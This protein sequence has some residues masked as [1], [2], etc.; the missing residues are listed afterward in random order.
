[1]NPQQKSQNPN[2]H[3]LA[4]ALLELIDQPILLELEHRNR[5]SSLALTGTLLRAFDDPLPTIA[6]TLTI[7][8]GAHS[9]SLRL[10]TIQQATIHHAPLPP[11]RVRSVHLLLHDGYS[12]HIKPDPAITTAHP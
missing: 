4:L 9:I 2:I 7:M 12:L 6:P 1:M 11:N 5:T 10:T 3:Q 8:I